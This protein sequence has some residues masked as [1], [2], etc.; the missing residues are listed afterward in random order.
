MI[1]WTTGGFA[2]APVATGVVV[3]LWLVSRKFVVHF[4]TFAMA[5][6]RPAVGVDIIVALPVAR[7]LGCP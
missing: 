3:P 2:A 4:A 1:G 5:G 7:C 6:A